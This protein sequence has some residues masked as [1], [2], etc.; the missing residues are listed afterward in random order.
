MLNIGKYV[1]FKFEML[2]F[3]Y[4]W[5]SYNTFLS[6]IEECIGTTYK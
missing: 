2:V 1:K 3:E 4:S 6:R 5:T